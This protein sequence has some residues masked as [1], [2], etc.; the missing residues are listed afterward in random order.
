[1]GHGYCSSDFTT[2]D[3]VLATY[4][5]GPGNVRKYRGVPPFA[6]T[7]RHVSDVKKYCAATSGGVALKLARQLFTI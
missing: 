2:F 7:R 1:M 5:S 6:E 3:Q 4:N